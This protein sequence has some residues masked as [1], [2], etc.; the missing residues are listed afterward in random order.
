VAPSGALVA[1]EGAPLLR[2][3]TATMA[4]TSARMSTTKAAIF[5]IDHGA[6]PTTSPVCPF[7]RNRYTLPWYR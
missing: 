3:A 7:T 1:L 4:P 5:A 2:D 6:T